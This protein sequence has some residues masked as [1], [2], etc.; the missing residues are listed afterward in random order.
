MTNED[1][2]E[3]LIKEIPTPAIDKFEK[4]VAVPHGG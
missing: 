1:I 2:I 3:R 4:P